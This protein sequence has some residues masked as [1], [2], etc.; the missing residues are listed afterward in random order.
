MRFKGVMPALITPLKADESLNRPVV[1]Q[2]INDLLAKGAQG[3]YVG[4]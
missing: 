3:F 4:G 2:L 1:G